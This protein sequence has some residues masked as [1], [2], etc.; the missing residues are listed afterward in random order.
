MPRLA[1]IH[2]N[3]DFPHMAENSRWQLLAYRIRSGRTDLTVPVLGPEDQSLPYMDA[4]ALQIARLENIATAADV[5][6]KLR[7]ALPPKPIEMLVA[8]RGMAFDFD[9]T[10]E[11]LFA[12]PIRIAARDRD[13]EGLARLAEAPSPTLRPASA[14]VIDALIEEGDWRGASDVAER[15]DPREQS[16]IE[17]FDDVRMLDYSQLQLILAAAAARD[18][19]DAAAQA[20]LARH[21]EAQI[22][23]DAERAEME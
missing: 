1:A 10:A 18:G 13:Y 19:D 11:A 14:I 21:I 4:A 6:R 22:I 12:A 2:F 23:V 17:G 9:P 15:H 20:Y 7:A 8:D 16:L 3:R 5:V